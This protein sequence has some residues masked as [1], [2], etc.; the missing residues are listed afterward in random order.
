M[1][2][3][4]KEKQ[5][6]SSLA[7]P[8]GAAAAAA[9]ATSVGE[10][11]ETKVRHGVG[12]RSEY[13][14]KWDAF[15]NDADAQLKA[16]EDEVKRHIA[17]SLSKDP[18]SEAQRKDLEKRAALREAKKQWDGVQINEEVMKICIS[19]ESNI[20]SRTICPTED[21]QNKRVLIL[22]NNN[23]CHYH[24]SDLSL[25]KVFI[26]KCTNCTFSLTC[27]INTS[28]LEISHCCD[29]KVYIDQHTVQ[30]IQIDLCSS[31]LVFY[32]QTLWEPTTKVYHS[33]VSDLRIEYDHSGITNG[34]TA[35]VD[36]S[37]NDSDTTYQL[38]DDLEM[39]KLNPHLRDSDQQFVTCYANSE[40]VTDLVLRDAGGH[41]TTQRE[42]DARRRQVEQAAREKGLDIEDPMVQKLLHEYDAVSEFQNG[43]KYKEEGNKV[44]KECDYA[45][46]SVHYTQAV[47][48]FTV[49]RNVTAV[50]AVDEVKKCNDQLCATYSN[51]AACLLKLG[52][53]ANAL[54]DTNACLEIDTIHVKAMFR[55]GLALHA[56][57]RYREACPVL[58]KASSLAPKDQSIKTALTFAE[59]KAQ[60]EG[61]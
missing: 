24:L 13:F 26:E 25:T 46:A 21:L 59:R 58:G 20:E 12:D 10:G 61:R 56:L 52:D 4:T 48:S 41:I 14:R 18:V 44:F 36:V 31:V 17:E 54:A 60:T 32:H 50:D 39:A 43:M 16:E 34:N 45:Q 2:E 42:I 22:R 28:T 29:L 55:K 27:K 23:N 30:T 40:L 7:T 35:V 57:G 8:S 11:D 5:E 19:G 3:F 49:H 6:D 37:L 33:G 1:S 51:R 38:L 47:E 15:A 53:H 9:A